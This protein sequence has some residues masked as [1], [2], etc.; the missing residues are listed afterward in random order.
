MIDKGSVTK[1]C[2][3]IS[4]GFDDILMFLHDVQT[5]SISI[6]YIALSSAYSNICIYLIY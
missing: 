3:L 5:N 2:N 4:C 6:N 1:E